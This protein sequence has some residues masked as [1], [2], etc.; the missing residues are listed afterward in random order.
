MIRSVFL[1]AVSVLLAGSASATSICP[2]SAPI[3]TYTAS[4]FSCTV[5]GLVFSQFTYSDATPITVIPITTP[6]QE[7]LEFDAAW[8]VSTNGPLVSQTSTIGF[9]VTGF[10]DSLRLSFQGSRTGSGAAMITENFDGNQL[11]ASDP[12]PSFSEP[13]FLFGPIE[14]PVITTTITVQ[15][16]GTSGT[17]NISKAFDNFITPEPIPFI[18]VGVGLL[19]VG[20]LRRRIKR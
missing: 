8:S 11:V 1:I 12:L 16:G 18:T 4:G 19:G 5:G 2:T 6:Q 10:L 7:G 3:A 9:T 13:L 14:S 15:A 20:L 17:A